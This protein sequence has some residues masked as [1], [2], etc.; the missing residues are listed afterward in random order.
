MLV[1]TGAHAGRIVYSSVQESTLV[2]AKQA[3]FLDWYEDWLDS[4]VDKRDLLMAA[5]Q[6][7]QKEETASSK[8]SGFFNGLKAWVQN[9]F[10]GK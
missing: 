7:S 6:R 3:G 9:I 5:R 10:T 4:I 8:D 1:V 2:F